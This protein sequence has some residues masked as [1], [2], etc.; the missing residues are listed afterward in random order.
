[1]KKH[2]N[3]VLGI[4]VL[5]VVW[6]TAFQLGLKAG[7]GK[8]HLSDFGDVAILAQYLDTVPPPYSDDYI[9]AVKACLGMIKRDIMSKS[10]GPNASNTIEDLKQRLEKKIQREL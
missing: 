8:E 10:L 2:R 3:I 6:I 5:C 9:L 7:A 4:L 1:M